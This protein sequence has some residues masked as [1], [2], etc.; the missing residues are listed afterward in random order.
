[1]EFWKLMLYRPFKKTDKDQFSFDYQVIEMTFLTKGRAIVYCFEI[2]DA[3]VC[4]LPI[5]FLFILE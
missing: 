1:M 5:K 3:I 2:I 4:Q